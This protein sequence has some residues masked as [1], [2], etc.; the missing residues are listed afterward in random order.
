MSTYR[1]SVWRLLGVQALAMFILWLPIWVVFLQRKGLSL[2]Q[3]G[4]LEAFAWILTAALEVPTGGIAD[5][6]GRRASIAIGTFLCAA[7]VC[8]AYVPRPPSH[9]GHAD[10]RVGDAHPRRRRTTRPRGSGRDA[11]RLESRHPDDA[12]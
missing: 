8:R 6:W 4:L 2:S 5:R 9:R 7:R 10:A 11:P 3:V 1:S 12:S